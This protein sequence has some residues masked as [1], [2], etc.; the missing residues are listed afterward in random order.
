MKARS[1]ARRQRSRARRC[2]GTP[3]I[4]EVKA[5]AGSKMAVTF[6]LIMALLGKFN[7]HK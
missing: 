2:P 6:S 3:K 1:A 4:A 5:L 7:S